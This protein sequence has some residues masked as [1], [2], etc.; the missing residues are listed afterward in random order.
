MGMGT[1][2]RWNKPELAYRAR[3]LQAKDLAG[4]AVGAMAAS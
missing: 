1:T 2:L 3:R 4:A